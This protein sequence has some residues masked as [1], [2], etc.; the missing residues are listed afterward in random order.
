MNDILNIIKKIFEK[1][2]I[3]IVNEN[4][5][6]DILISFIYKGQYSY[7]TS[8]GMIYIDDLNDEDKIHIKKIIAFAQRKSKINKVLP[9]KN[10]NLNELKTVKV[11]GSNYYLLLQ[12]KN[13][14]MLFKENGIFGIEYILCE[15]KKVGSKYEYKNIT[16]YKD[17]RIAEHNLANRTQLY[18]KPISYFSS[19]AL[20]VILYYIRTYQNIEKSK[21]LIEISNN[22]QKSI[23]E[24][25]KGEENE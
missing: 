6:G 4:E 3:E 8:D 17:I 19:E 14:C 12:I 7:I 15:E 25:L 10:I 9:I 13:Q 18:I 23:I 24:I 2:N 16:K 20:Q 1:E 21:H 5:N 22:I 11:Y